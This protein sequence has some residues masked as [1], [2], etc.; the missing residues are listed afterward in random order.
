M[1]A[2]VKADNHGKEKSRSYLSN[3]P[4]NIDVSHGRRAP[5]SPVLGSPNQNPLIPSEKISPNYLKPTISFSNEFCKYANRQASV[6]VTLKRLKSRKSVNKPQSPSQIK[7]TP[8]SF[9]PKAKLL[10][11]S[12]FSP[13]N[14]VSPKSNLNKILKYGN[15]QPLAK[16]RSLKN[17]E[18]NVRREARDASNKS[19]SDNKK[20]NTISDGPKEEDPADE[21]VI[22]MVCTMETE[23][24]HHEILSTHDQ[25]FYD[26]KPETFNE[27]GL[28]NEELGDIKED[29]HEK[30]EEVRNE[31]GVK[32]REELEKIIDFD[33]EDGM[34]QRVII[35]RI[36]AVPMDF[37]K[38]E[39]A[40]KLKFRQRKEID[41]SEESNDMEFEKLK[42]KVRGD[43]KGVEDFTKLDSENVVLK[44]KEFQGKK[45]AMAFNDVIEETASKLVEESK[46]VVKA[47]VGAFETVILL[48]E[49]E[50]QSPRAVDDDGKIPKAKL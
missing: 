41:G 4:E 50:S 12:S 25:I 44:H 13:R 21:V 30:D 18:S 48:Q 16:T 46:S 34:Y 49:S 24:G 19:T 17:E 28:I 8:F 22:E 14:A 42:F 5:K 10:R 31:D 9:S 38:E 29:I 36:R 40:T 2:K 23:H 7:K 27:V 3:R 33:C 1:A 32:I 15:F 6:R 39:K 47:L 43:A 35:Q 11:S 45:G 37:G 26:S 20:P